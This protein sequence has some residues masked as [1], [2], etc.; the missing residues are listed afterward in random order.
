M[1]STTAHST[2]QGVHGAEA[3]DRPRATQGVTAHLAALAAGRFAAGVTAAARR[4]S[5]RHLLDTLGAIV[6]GAGQAPSRLAAETL[7][8]VTAPG[9][10]RVP[11]DHTRRWDALNAAYLMGVAAHGLE[12]DDGYTGGSVHPGAPVVPALLAAAQLRPV[13]GERLLLAMAVGYE[14]VAR[15]AAGIHPASRRRGFHNTALVGPLAAA[16]AVGCLYG[17]D[18]SAIESAIGLAASSA[19]GLFAFLNGGG[20]VKRLHA[21][22]AARE[23]LLA[24]LL[25]ER[26]MRGPVAVLEGIDGFVQAF[27]DPKTSSL[28]AAAAMRGDAST[29]AAVT[30]CYMKPWA[31]CRHL[32][33]ALDALFAIRRDAGV[34]ASDVERIDVDTYAI[35]AAH[36][37]IG[38]QDMLSAQMSYPFAMAVAL[39]RG[40][41]DLA[42]FRDDARTGC[43]DEAQIAALCAR[44]HV[45]V[46]PQFDATYPSTR[47]ARVRVLCRD[48]S[49]HE[50]SVNDGYGSH[51]DPLD[52]A[53]L[54]AKFDGLAAPVL[55]AEPTRALRAALDGV[56]QTG[57][58]GPFLRQ[59]A[60]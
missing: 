7:G 26:G 36:A 58:A 42:D 59:L 31:C 34:R 55:G 40:H 56:E 37:R 49:V 45:D 48:G 9:E 50:R 22:H 20:D 8:S 25:A 52:E 17:L 46:D 21:G 29:P 12:L 11:G 43:A 18:A 1:I 15:L 33:P 5:R 4:A 47:M 41:A 39:A 30:Q 38:W 13:D 27:G 53:A 16:G 51:I 10:V 14:L 19:A 6:A 57:D 32:H 24:V 23:G 54:A 44:V 3:G 60:A 28:L 35:G 2:D